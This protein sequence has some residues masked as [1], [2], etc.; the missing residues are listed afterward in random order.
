MS[1]FMTV[2]ILGYIF[3]GN[4]IP[5]I[6]LVNELYPRE[7]YLFIVPGRCCL[8]PKEFK[9]VKFIGLIRIEA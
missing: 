5:D 2:R 6:K 1:S 8:G 4:H 3:M 9:F 7:E